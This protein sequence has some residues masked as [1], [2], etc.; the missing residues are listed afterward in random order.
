MIKRMSLSVSVG[1]IWWIFDWNIMS[2]LL[3]G[4]YTWLMD[5]RIKLRE[6]IRWEIVVNNYG[7]LSPSFDVFSKGEAL[8]QYKFIVPWRLVLFDL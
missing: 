7:L 6:V 8:K 5:R 2:F 4:K 3:F 1:V